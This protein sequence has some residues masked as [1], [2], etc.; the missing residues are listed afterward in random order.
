MKRQVIITTILLIATAYI[1]VLYFKNLNPPGSHTSRLM[2]N[3]PGNAAV[4]FE[5]NN[6]KSFYD[7]FNDNILLTALVGPEKLADIDTVRN[8]LLGNP[9]LAKYFD[10]QN[11]FISLHP[12]KDNE[13]D[14][15]L[16]IS[17]GKGFDASLIAQLAKQPNN[18]LIITTEK[19]GGKQGYGIFINSIKERFYVINKEDDIFSGTF[20]E[21]LAEQSAQYRSKS[22]QKDFV[23]LSEQQNSNSLGNL[24][25]NYR[26]LSPLLDH[27]FKNKNTDIFR[28]FKLLPA[29]AVLSL[30]YKSD[31]FM[32]NGITTIQHDQPL[33]YLNLFTGQQPVANH[34]KDIFPA[35]T[36]YSTNFSVSDPLKFQSDLAQWYVKAGLQREKDSVFKK[37]KTETGVSLRTEFAN[38]LGNEFAVVTTRYQEKFAIVSLKDGSKMRPLMGNIS[39]M[40]TDNTGQFTYS[41]LP[42][43]L[44]GDAFNIFRR[45]Y[46]MILDN[47]LILA[48]SSAE[49]TSYYDTYINRKFISKMD[50]Y[51]A[52]DNLLSERSNVAF[53]INFKNAQP[54]LKNDLNDYFYDAFETY[55]PGWKNFYGVSYQFSAAD[56]NFYTN[57]C[58]KLNIDTAT[59]KNN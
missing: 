3:I 49:L 42:F 58:M 36:A 6:E 29:L 22:D 7:I 13:V 27:L 40:V 34:L 38:L 20:S 14:L 21:D 25:V 41:K 8:Q 54:I 16:T 2:S 56:N 11:V 46:F 33:S 10:G 24:Y 17:A 15:L 44:L 26:Q 4:I 12:T 18:D 53:F 43:F 35:T 47:Y 23:L 9:I 52:F 32:F 55:E 31:A 57:F 50:S 51:N 19:I 59:V 48:N 1:T 28:G 45:P 30:N 5:F 39:H 37:V